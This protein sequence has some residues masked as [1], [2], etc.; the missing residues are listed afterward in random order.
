MAYQWDP[1]KAVLNLRSHGVDFADAISALEDRW[2][3]TIK[4]H[5]VD[6]EQRFATIGTDSLGR[7]VVVVY[8]YRDDDIRVISA[9]KATKN[10]RK[11]YEGKRR[12]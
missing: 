10:E 4:E 5:F 7:V 1:K 11:S 6:R 8:T 12:V 2:A 9:R 3:L